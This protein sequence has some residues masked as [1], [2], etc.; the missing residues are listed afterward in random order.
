[1]N[2]IQSIGKSLVS[3]LRPQNTPKTFTQVSML[4]LRVVA[5]VVIFHNGLDKISD[6]PGFAEAY[7]EVIGLPFPIFFAYIASLTELIC[8][9]LLVMGLFTRFAGLGLTSTMLIA[10]Y[11]HLLVAGFSIPA[12]ELTSLYCATF[13]YFAVNGAGQFSLDQVIS[14]R[15]FPQMS[16]K[17]DKKSDKTQS[18]ATK[19]EPEYVKAE[20]SKSY[21]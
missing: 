7:V 15:F 4:I 14:D 2:S 11:H 18:G 9:P 3:L 6:I 20:S 8:A 21:R 5:G 13:A 12:I 16:D 17:S 10:V 1:M 19:F